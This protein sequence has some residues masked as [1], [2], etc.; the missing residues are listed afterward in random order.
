MSLPVPLSVRVGDRHI[1]RE[2][3]SLSFRREAVGGV[4]SI[5]FGLAR[6]LSDLN[7]LE[8]LSQVFVY[9][10]R[11]AATVAQGRLADAGRTAAVDGGQSWDVVAF[12]P[13]QSAS[14]WTGPLIYLDRDLGAWRQ[15]SASNAEH[16]LGSGSRPDGTV[17][18]TGLVGVFREGVAFSPAEHVTIRYDRIRASGQKLGAYQIANQVA[19]VTDAATSLDG[20]TAN[21]DAAGGY[22]ALDTASSVT[23]STATAAFL[24]RAAGVDFW[25]A[26]EVL[27]LRLTY[28]GDGGVNGPDA[29]VFIDPP[30]VRPVFHDQDGTEITGV[31]FTPG[32]IEP[33]VEE[34]VAD[35]LGRPGLMTEFDSA[36]ATITSSVSQ[37][38]QMAY[39]DGITPA[40]VLADL[41]GLAPAYRWYTTPDQT[42]DGYG[43]SW[44][45]WPTTVRYEATLDDGGSFPLSSQDVYNRVNVRWVDPYG[46]T[47][48][49]LRSL[50]CPVLDNEGL[51]RQATIDLGAEVGSQAQAEAAGDAFLIEHNIPKNAGTL[52]VARAIRDVIT[53]AMVDPWEIEAGELVRIL[54]VEAYPDAFN[55][56]TNDGQGVFRIFA[57]DYTSEGNTATLALDS[58][59]RETADALVKLL[60]QR[61]R[62]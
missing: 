40:Q 61:S 38:T 51:I 6:P 17:G 36:T 45:L 23:L 42:G 29:W 5:S 3:K 37:V 18:T 56:S 21:V 60:K 16:Q 33:L 10:T 41:M 7:G 34:V 31:A 46:A 50:A 24:N 54:G 1:T 12:G 15:I 52:T 26:R 30:F 28:A 44:D 57:V 35:L 9:D 47:Q 59:P 20:L 4:R 2:V 25:T 48:G 43:F 13:A 58:D 19:G 62:R 14:D 22:V 27:D 55:A 11:S 53:G 32:T 39:P 49:T 8:P